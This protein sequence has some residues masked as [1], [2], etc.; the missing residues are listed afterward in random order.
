MEAA[1]E[2]LV[3]LVGWLRLAAETISVLIIGVG[4]IITLYQAIRIRL[5]AGLEVY[6]KARVGLGHFLVLGLEFQLAS[7]IMS[8]AMAP[9]WQ[10]LGQLAAIAAIRTFLNYFLLREQR[11]VAPE[12]EQGRG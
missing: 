8:T 1:E 4:V 3:A 7:D 5:F 2:L 9:S 12:R 11:E 6:Q 10:Q